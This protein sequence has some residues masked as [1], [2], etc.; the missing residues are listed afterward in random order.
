MKINEKNSLDKIKI[1]IALMELTKHKNVVR[2]YET[3]LYMDCL[4]MVIEYMD[5]GALTDIIY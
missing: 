1:E 5:G 4:F 2:Y 3:Y